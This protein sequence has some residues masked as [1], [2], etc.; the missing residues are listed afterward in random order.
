M[1]QWAIYTRTPD[2]F[3]T[4][5]FSYIPF[6]AVVP[7]TRP[8]PNYAATFNTVADVQIATLSWDQAL[9]STWKLRRRHR[10]TCL[11]YI[12]LS[13]SVSILHGTVAI[14]TTGRLAP[15]RDQNDEEKMSALLC[16][17]SSTFTKTGNKTPSL[18]TCVYR[19]IAEEEFDYQ[20]PDYTENLALPP[21]LTASI[22][23]STSTHD[24]YSDSESRNSSSNRK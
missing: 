17:Q 21:S 24:P 11:V 4:Y 18:I 20:R 10:T 5:S 12:A 23:M 9:S 14:P 3:P 16:M 1:H 7:I 13:L 2:T 19:K 22:A 15:Y 6:S 8:S